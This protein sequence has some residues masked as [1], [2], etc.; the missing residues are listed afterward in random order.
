[1]FGVIEDEGGR[2][3]DGRDA[4][5]GRGIGG[6]AGVHGKRGKARA[7]GLVG[8]ERFSHSRGWRR[9]FIHFNLIDGHDVNGEVVVS[10][11]SRAIR[12]NCST[13]GPIAPVGYSPRVRTPRKA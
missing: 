12:A 13:I 2:L 3:V 6:G 8:H 5:A 9:D 10:I 1:M 11:L 7:R 4:G